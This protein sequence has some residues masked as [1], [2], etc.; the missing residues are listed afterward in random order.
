MRS[1]P[2]ILT[3]ENVEPISQAKVQ[4]GDLTVLVGPQASGKS[5]FLQTLKLAMDR[6]HILR[7]FE[8]QNV[9]FGN[10]PAAV[11]SGFYGRGMGGMLNSEAK[12]F[13]TWDGQRYD[14]AQLTKF[15]RPKKKIK[16]HFSTFWHNVLLAFRLEF[17]KLL[18]VLTLVIRM[19]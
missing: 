1:K 17:R 7:F 16:N 8:Q 13:V 10:D 3:L 2:P 14:L 11:L 12:P 6:N 9:V 18:E 5:V 19:F 15:K 4:F